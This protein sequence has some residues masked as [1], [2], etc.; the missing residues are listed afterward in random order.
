MLLL[1]DQPLS[2]HR[3]VF[4]HC[5]HLYSYPL[6]QML[7]EG[8][9]NL[10]NPLP[11]RGVRWVLLLRSDDA[12]LAN[13]HACATNARPQDQQPYSLNPLALKLWYLQ[14]IASTN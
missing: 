14:I 10:A 3:P 13:K 2:L 7:C 9:G 1:Q 4:C 8:V 11:G 6:I 12:W 5:L